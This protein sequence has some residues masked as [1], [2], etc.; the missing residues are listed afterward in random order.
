MRAWLFGFL[1]ISCCDISLYA[2][3]DKPHMLSA[4]W[5][6]EDVIELY[7]VLMESHPHPDFYVPI[8]TIEYAFDALISFCDNKDSIPADEYFELLAKALGSLHDSH[9][10]LPSRDLLDWMMGEGLYY[11]PFQTLRIDTS[12][13]ND[14]G[15]VVIKGDWGDKLPKGAELIAINGV[16]VQEDY[17]Y[18]LHFATFEGNARHSAL[19]DAAQMIPVLHGIR[20]PYDT[21]NAITI[22]VLNSPRDTTIFLRGLDAKS[23]RLA[24]KERRKTHRWKMSDEID[25]SIDTLRNVG[26][27]KIATF[28]PSWYVGFNHQL[29]NA[30]REFESA[31]VKAVIVDIR[32]NRGGSG[33]QVE[34][35]YSYIDPRGCIT[36]NNT[37][38]LKSDLTLQFSWYLSHPKWLNLGY[39]FD[40][41]DEAF[42][43]FRQLVELDYLGQDTI[44]HHEPTVQ[45]EYV[46]VGPCYLLIDGQS[47]SASV[48]FTHHFISKHRGVVVGEP[49][50]GS[51]RGTFGN[52]TE[53]RM[54]FN[55]LRV[56]I[57]TIRY[58]YDRTFY[59]EKEPI[60]PDHRVPMNQPDY[61]NGVDTQLEYIYHLIDHLK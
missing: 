6:Y 43:L 11:P 60:N 8:D 12:C 34:Q 21:L 45:E 22:R 58:N 28:D 50:N 26:Y 29:N 40:P 27:V 10:A 4:E 38:W 48:D 31:K 36:P 7:D 13:S 3:R 19:Q 5:C 2:Q 30:F 18:A 35:L 20:H 54:Y 42:N 23:F 37:I 47:A 55:W 49:C 32:G 56:F 46:Y 53:H 44:F 24:E 14:F 39:F 16:P 41:E 17:E 51:M 61:V 15:Q 52:A 25:Y 59:S 33:Q 9:V 57:P 1:L